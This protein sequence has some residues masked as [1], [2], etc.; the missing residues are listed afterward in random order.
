MNISYILQICIGFIGLVLIAIPFSSN[1]KIINYKHILSAI[2]FQLFLAFIL[3]KVPVITNLFSYLADAV[4]ALQ[5][6]PGK[7]TEFVF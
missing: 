7:G 2:F 4:A 1:I 5:I 6:A 3:I